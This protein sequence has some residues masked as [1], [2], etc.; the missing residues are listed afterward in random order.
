MV[1]ERADSE[2]S[3]GVRQRRPD[4]V[5][6]IEELLKRRLCRE[7]VNEE[8]IGRGLDREL[9]AEEVEEPNDTRHTRI[10]S[11]QHEVTLADEDDLPHREVPEPLEPGE[12]P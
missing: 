6:E 5:L 4:L 2:R 12:I 1:V 8:G 9:E 3:T 7:P 10:P 11:A